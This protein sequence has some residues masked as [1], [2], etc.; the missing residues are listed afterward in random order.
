MATTPILIILAGGASSRMWPL[1]EKSLL[2]FGTESLLV[3]QLMRY[4]AL[5]FQEAVIVANPE[6]QVDI[7]QLVSQISTM[8]VRIVVQ[9]E[10]KGMGDALLRA[11]SALAGRFDSPIYIN[12]VHDVV[13]DRLHIDLLAAY[14][15][16]P[17]GSYLAGYVMESYFPGGYLIVDG[18]GRISGMVEKPAPENRPSNLVNI[19]AHIHANA[20][21]LFE[22]I[23]AEYAR[24]IPTDDHYERAMDNL[25]KTQVF[26]VVP[27]NGQ[28]SALKFPWHVLDVMNYYLNQIN[29]QIVAESAF[30]AS[31][32][33]LVGNVYIGER[34]KIFPGAAVVGPAYI[35]ADTVLGNNSLVRGS[36]V[37]NHCEVGFTTEIA[38]SYV[39]DHCSMHACR[40]LDSV[41]APNVNF[42][43][44]CTT[45]NLRIDR[46]AVS[47][48]VKGTKLSTGRDKLGAIIGA[49]AF[50]GVDA[51]TMPGVKIGENAQVG[52]GTH[53]RHDVKNG[54]RVYVKQEI[55]IIEGTNE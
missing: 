47:S 18:S 30:V 25:M 40:V 53:V 51:M 55:Q 4:R 5:G 49:N 43:A 46:K 28:W 21:R 32:A 14:N 11:E 17:T 27:Y 39:S 7:T 23:R 41:F 35:G 8:N 9:P 16:D 36:M 15:A 22:A 6:N 31:T 2:R 52:P 34:V 10:P 33:S 54:H 48:V 42:S 24:D 1:R 44:G 38:R 20:G 12:Q 29:G 45:A 50:I 37:L 3:S 26:R 13:E 19:V